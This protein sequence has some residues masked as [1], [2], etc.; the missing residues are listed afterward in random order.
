M[1]WNIVS[2]HKWS[3]SRVWF[4]LKLW[5][6]CFIHFHCDVRVWS[7]AEMMYLC[8]DCNIKALERYGRKCLE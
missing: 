7:K 3:P 4:V 6:H 5:A 8:Y 1:S 2:C